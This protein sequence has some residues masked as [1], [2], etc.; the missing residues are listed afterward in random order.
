MIELILGGQ[1]VTCSHQPPILDGVVL[2]VITP[3]DWTH[4]PRSWLENSHRAA[5]AAT[6]SG[7]SA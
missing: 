6:T 4:L 2:P 1:L 7:T 3:A 5:P